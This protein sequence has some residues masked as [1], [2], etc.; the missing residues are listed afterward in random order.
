MYRRRPSECGIDDE[1]KFGITIYGYDAFPNLYVAPHQS[2]EI[3]SSA[4]LGDP[5]GIISFIVVKSA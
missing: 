3:E 1:V 5:A 4:D 2:V